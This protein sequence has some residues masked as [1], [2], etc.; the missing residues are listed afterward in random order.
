M[1][2]EEGL[3]EV[4][5]RQSPLKRLEVDDAAYNTGATLITTNAGE[6]INYVVVMSALEPGAPIGAVT[7]LT[8]TG[9]IGFFV[10][11]TQPLVAET[12]T[13]V[14]T[15]SPANMVSCVREVFRLT[16]SDTSQVLRVSRPTVYQWE[17]L[18]DIAAI[19]ARTDR[20]RLMQIYR[21]AQDWARRPLLRGRWLHARL[22][23][24]KSVFDLLSEQPL[25]ESTLRHAY[26]QVF[27][28]LPDLQANEQRRSAAAVKAMKGAF[29]KLAAN[30]TKRVK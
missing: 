28:M 8:S 13:S 2:A 27:A 24:G 16:V 23:S 15:P 7:P 20:D 6:Y 18:G 30:E 22:P 21:L 26:D 19:R 5:A 25:D 10:H 4:I 3:R 17:S 1:S 12:F 11:E 14:T 9:S 29:G